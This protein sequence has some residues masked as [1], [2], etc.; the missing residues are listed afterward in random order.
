MSDAPRVTIEQI[1]SKVASEYYFTALDGVM[2][3]EGHTDGN[4]TRVV[5]HVALSL[6]TFCVLVL[7]TGHT[8]VGKSACVS[9]ANFDAVLG[10]KYAREDAIKQMWPLEGYLLSE[11]LYEDG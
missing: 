7:H 6:T 9:A 8:I 4:Y 11:R 5:D 10:R 3:A 2:G 1:E